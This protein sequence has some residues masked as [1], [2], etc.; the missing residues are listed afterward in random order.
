MRITIITL[1]I[2]AF[3]TISCSSG[4]GGGGSAPVYTCTTTDYP[5]GVTISGNGEYE[6]RVAGNGIVSPSPRPIRMA[7]VKIYN[8]NTLVQCGATDDNGAFSLKVPQSSASHTVRISSVIYNAVT[9]AFV[10]NNPSNRLFHSIETTVVPDTTKSAGTLTAEAENDVKGGAFNILDQAHTANEFLVDETTGC[11]STFADCPV[12]TGAPLVRIFWDKGV[13]PGTYV[14]SQPLSFYLPGYRELY[15]LGGEDGDVDSSDCDHF[16][17]SV[18]LH[19]YGHFIEDV[20]SRSNSPGGFHDGESIIDPRLAWGE[21]WANFFQAAITG[22]PLY[23]DTWGNGGTT[24]VYFNESLEVPGDDIA[25]TMGEGNFREFSISRILWDAIDSINEGAGI[26]QVTSPFSELWT[27]FADPINGFASTS[28]RFRNIGLFHTLQQA[29]PNAQDWSSIRTGENH[30]G[31]QADYARAVLRGGSCSPINIQAASSSTQTENGQAANSNQF[32]SNDF[33]AYYHPGGTFSFTLNYT[34]TP[35]PAADLDV[36]LFAENY[37]FTKPALAQAKTAVVTSA[38]SGTETITANLA[39]G[40]Y[41]INVRVNTT[42]GVLGNAANYT[43]T[44]GGQ[45]LCPN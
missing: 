10:L 34:T 20:F 42:G 32:A 40:Y 31:S 29:L 8:G 26:D 3:S 13:D 16:D 9:K 15:I 41:M 5:N 11:K 18:I 21:G 38:S 24:G 37:V 27:I 2:A 12:F 39:A 36:Y 33:Y 30:V 23:R 43:M 6:F 17:N 25:S 45:S 35:N 28:H 14:N 44:L 4:G 22:V 19:E 1:S 7:E